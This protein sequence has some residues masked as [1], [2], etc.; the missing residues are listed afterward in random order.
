M[1]NTQSSKIDPIPPER[2]VAPSL[3]IWAGGEVTTLESIAEAYKLGLKFD[4]S[5]VRVNEGLV[6]G[7]ELGKYVAIDCEM[8]GVGHEG[9]VDSLARVSA[10]DFLG[11][12][13]YDSYVLQRE[14]VVDWRTKVSGVAPRHMKEARPFEEVQAQMMAVLRGRVLIGHDVKHDLLALEIKHIDSMIRDTSRHAGFQKYAWGLRPSLR[15][16]AQELLGV[17]IQK[18]E[19]SSLEDARVA[20][21]LFRTHKTAFD[22]EHL[23]RF[24]QPKKK[25]NKKDQSKSSKTT[26]RLSDVEKKKGI[27]A[28]AKS[29][30]KAKKSRGKKR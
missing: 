4:D 21:L 3:S 23:R 22:M 29:R 24:P 15:V 1:G 20:M 28:K 16:L 13:I 5:P 14:K 6:P 19:H 12:Q 27:K 30:A 25:P 18:G 2:G 17:E 26:R 10:V 8:V 9:R 7:L 11:Q